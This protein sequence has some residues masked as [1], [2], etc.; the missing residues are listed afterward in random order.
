MILFTVVTAAATA[1][2]CALF[3]IGWVLYR[4]REAEQET[5]REV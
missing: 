2:T 4:M 5:N 1:G 3:E